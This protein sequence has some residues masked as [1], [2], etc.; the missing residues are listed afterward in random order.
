MLTVW[1]SRQTEKVLSVR[2]TAQAAIG[3]DKAAEAFSDYVNTVNRVDTEDKSKKMK[4]RLEKLKDIQE[5]R[6]QP[7]QMASSRQKS[8]RTVSREDTEA[9][10]P[11]F[12]RS[13]KDFRP[14]RG[15]E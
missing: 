14:R 1:R 2:A 11:D 8:V 6:F 15:K 4:E 12:K 9:L 13:V 5:I 7:M 10:S 3:G